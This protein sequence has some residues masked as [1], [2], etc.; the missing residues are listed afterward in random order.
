MKGVGLRVNNEGRNVYGFCPFEAMEKNFPVG[1]PPSIP[2]K[3]V[4][5]DR[6]NWVCIHFLFLL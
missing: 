4:A 2:V 5:V 3:N 1:P 6:G